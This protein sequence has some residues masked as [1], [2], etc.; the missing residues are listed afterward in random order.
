MHAPGTWHPQTDRA[1]THQ[2]EEDDEH[3]QQ[4]HCSSSSGRCQCGAIHRSNLN[5]APDPNAQV[6][7]G[8][9]SLLVP[10]PYRGWSDCSKMSHQYVPFPGLRRL[11]AQSQD[12]GGGSRAQQNDLQQTT[13]VNVSEQSETD[14]VV[15]NFEAILVILSHQRCGDPTFFSVFKKILW[16]RLEFL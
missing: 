4:R 7:L 6:L 9:V 1:F 16:K 2:W 3:F 10:G 13:G 12:Q 14:F 11:S 5:T 8:S 15:T